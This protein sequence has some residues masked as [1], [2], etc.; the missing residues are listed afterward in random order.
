MPV[1]SPNIKMATNTQPFKVFKYVYMDNLKH[2]NEWTCSICVILYLI[3]YFLNVPH[4][5]LTRLLCVMLLLVWAHRTV[6][7]T[8][9]PE[10]YGYGQS[11][12]H[13]L[14]LHC[15]VG[16]YKR[17]ADSTKREIRTSWKLNPVLWRP[18]EGQFIKQDMEIS[19]Y[20]SRYASANLKQL[21]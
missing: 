12:W 11:A 5:V 2:L 21:C 4:D 16:Y 14:A 9:I 6:P 10:S 13:F 18:S 19:T 20:S 7:F 17:E 8:V 3:V 15:F 1:C